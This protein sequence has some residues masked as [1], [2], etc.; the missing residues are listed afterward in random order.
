VFHGGYIVGDT[1]FG[2]SQFCRSYGGYYRLDTDDARSF[3]E[4]YVP[5]P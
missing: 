4:D 1:S 5:V 3:L 2:S